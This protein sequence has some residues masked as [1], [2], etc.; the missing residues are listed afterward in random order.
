MNG[1]VN[2]QKLLSERLEEIDAQEGIL[3]HCC[4]AAC[5]TY[6]MEYLVAKL[7]NSAIGAEKKECS[8]GGG[9][10]SRQDGCALQENI[11]AAKEVRNDGCAPIDAEWESM[12]QGYESFDKNFYVNK[13]KTVLYYCNPNIDSAREYGLRAAELCRFNSEAGYNFPVIVEKYAPQLFYDAVK[14]VEGAGEG[15]ERCERCFGLRFTLA[16][17]KAKE[18]GCKYVLST[19]SISPHKNAVRLYEIGK[20]CGQE[21]GVEFLPSD[22]KKEGGFVR[23]AALCARYGIYRQSYC[24]CAYSKIEKELNLRGGADKTAGQTP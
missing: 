20:E 19:L 21:N 7:Q 11:L 15:S 24:G 17:A 4:C 1:N 23:S 3:V 6:C 10:E 12:A 5:S 13:S 8:I 16:A 14:G 18:I 22:F 9:K 2:L